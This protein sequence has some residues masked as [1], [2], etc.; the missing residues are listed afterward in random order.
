M[1]KAQFEFL[2]TGTSQGVPIIG[3][4]CNVCL[5]SDPKDH[6]LRTAAYI[7]NEQ[8]G[9]NIDIGTDFRHQMLRAGHGDTNAILITHEHID[10]INGLDDVRPI[11]YLKEKVLPVFA[12]QRVLEQIR[13]RFP[14]IFAYSAYP[15]LPQ[16]DLIPIR[17]GEHIELNGML[18]TV[19]RVMHGDL[20]ILGFRIGDLAY[21]TD[22]KTLPDET[23]NALKQIRTLIISSLH[24]RPHHSHMNFKESLELASHFPE[25]DIYFTHCSHQMGTYQ[26]ITERLPANVALAYDGLQ[27]TI[28]Y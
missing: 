7:Q 12:E 22:V 14:Y 16:I 27:L 6:R 13:L 4:D 1:P 15:G 3:C 2:G 20:P 26:E 8:G 18:I 24:H 5:S 9:L 19:L 25:A 10:H 11:N 17:A 21:L 23:M 28:N